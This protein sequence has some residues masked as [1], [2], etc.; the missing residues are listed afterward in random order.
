MAT[1]LGHKFLFVEEEDLG[2]DPERAHGRVIFTPCLHPSNC[3]EAV[4]EVGCHGHL[5]LL[6]E[7]RMFLA[8]AYD[9]QGMRTYVTQ[10]TNSPRC[11]L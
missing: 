4:A 3:W 2:N 9:R 1:K 11:C 6:S 7:A 5:L 10:A 8:S